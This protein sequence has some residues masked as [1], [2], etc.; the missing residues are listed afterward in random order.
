[1]SDLAWQKSSFSGGAQDNCVEVAPGTGHVHL[2]ESDDPGVVLSAD[3]SVFRALVTH[4]K[5]A[6]TA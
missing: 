6:R 4:L 1:M 3:R 2:R 5:A